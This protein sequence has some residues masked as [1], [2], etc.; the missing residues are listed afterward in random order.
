MTEE[1][2]LEVREVLASRQRVQTHNPNCWTYEG[3]EDC[4]AH[5]L[6]SEVERL[7]AMLRAQAREPRL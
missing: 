2:I 3:H 4:M 1:E 7:N 6:L 5:M